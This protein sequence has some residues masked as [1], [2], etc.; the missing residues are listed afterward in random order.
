MSGFLFLTAVFLDVLPA[1]WFIGLQ[2][3]VSHF[4][5]AADEGQ[6]PSLISHDCAVRTEYLYAKFKL[7]K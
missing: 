1:R 5:Y 2:T 7:K 3:Q 6:L 4:C